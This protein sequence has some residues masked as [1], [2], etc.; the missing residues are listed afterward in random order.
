MSPAHSSACSATPVQTRASTRRLRITHSRTCSWRVCAKRS[1][2]TACSCRKKGSGCSPPSAQ[3]HELA[4]AGRAR[5]ASGRAHVAER[6]ES[7]RGAE[8]GGERRVPVRGRA[9]FCAS[10]HADAGLG[11]GRSRCR[12]SKRPGQPGRCRPRHA[13]GIRGGSVPR[14]QGFGYSLHADAQRASGDLAGAEQSLRQAS[15]IRATPSVTKRLDKV[16]V[17]SPLRERGITV[18]TIPR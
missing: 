14:A 15:A 8:A 11:G 17:A 5:F 16:R 7:S 4:V 18:A 2:E 12:Q 1:P 9:D 10:C 6:G 13:A 3:C